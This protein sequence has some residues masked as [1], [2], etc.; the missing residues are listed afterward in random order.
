MMDSQPSLP[1]SSSSPPSPPPSSPPRGRGGGEGGGG[2]RRAA[3]SSPPINF[4]GRHR[5]AAAIS[6]LHHQIDVIKEELEQLDTL[7]ESSIACRELFS[8]VESIPDPL[9]PTTQG[10]VDMSW[11]RWFR[12]AHE[13]K[14]HKRWI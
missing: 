11:E 12:G 4:L 1:S 5:M 9:L 3:A 8:S 7:G 10:P 13:S 6:Q 14:S 2:K